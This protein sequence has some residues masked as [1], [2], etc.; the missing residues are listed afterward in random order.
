MDDFSFL[1][2]ILY[3]LLLYTEKIKSVLISKGP[4]FLKR[5]LISAP[6]P[7]LALRYLG[8][9]AFASVSKILGLWQI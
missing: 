7:K 6:P 1:F 8:K 2:C 3:S 4:L 5:E 9:L